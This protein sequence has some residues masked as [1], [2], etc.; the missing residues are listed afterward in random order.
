[1]RKRY[2]L[3]VFGDT[4]VELEIHLDDR[5]LGA[6]KRLENILDIIQKQGYMS[7]T[8][9]IEFKD[10]LDEDDCHGVKP[11]DYEKLSKGDL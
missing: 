11:S 4:H 1:M 6:I 9:T 7:F 10:K 5:E 2:C 3:D 8:P